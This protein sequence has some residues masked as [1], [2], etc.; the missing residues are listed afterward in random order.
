[1]TSLVNNN[2]VTELRR[3]AKQ[4]AN[5]SHPEILEKPSANLNIINHLWLPLAQPIAPWRPS[6]TEIPRPTDNLC[7][8]LRQ[9]ASHAIQIRLNS[10]KFDQEYYFSNLHRRFPL[11]VIHYAAFLLAFVLVSQHCANPSDQTAPK[12]PIWHTFDTW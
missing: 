12:D 2:R 6:W 11:N 10:T 4:N 1:L 5:T 9:Y 3:T 8:P 7:A